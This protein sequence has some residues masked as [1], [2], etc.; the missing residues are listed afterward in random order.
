VSSYVQHADSVSCLKGENDPA[1]IALTPM[2][3]CLQRQFENA[4]HLAV[5]VVDGC[6]EKEQGTDR[7]TEA[8]DSRTKSYLIGSDRI[9]E[10]VTCG[11]R[12]R[13]FVAHQI[14]LLR[15]SSQW[16]ALDQL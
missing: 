16:D 10:G 14:R 5:N 6:S 13:D 11:L 1:V 9:D 8:A 3:L 7:P 12:S 2:Q 4:D 15:L